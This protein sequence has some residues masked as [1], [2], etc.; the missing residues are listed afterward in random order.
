MGRTK[1]F[2]KKILNKL[3]SAFSKVDKEDYEF[4]IY[5]Q[6]YGLGEKLFNSYISNEIP[7]KNIEKLFINPM[8]KKIKPLKLF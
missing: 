1:R 4:L 8:S 5:N 3:E 2:L 7:M 6:G